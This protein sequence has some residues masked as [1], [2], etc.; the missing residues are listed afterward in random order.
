MRTTASKPPLV[1]DLRHEVRGTGEPLLLVHGTGSS[2]RVWDPLV[3][4]LAA[5]RTVI[6]VDLPGFGASA[7]LTPSGP[8]PPPVSLASSPTSSGNSG[9][10]GAL[11]LTYGASV[12]WLS[13]ATPNDLGQI[14]K[15]SPSSGRVRGAVSTGP[16]SAS[17]ARRP[18]PGRSGR[19]RWRTRRAGSRRCWSS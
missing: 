11:S 16:T 10:A 2:L 13:Q 18:A 3:E 6:A 4:R 19:P 9:T 8:A 1:Q 15:I 17:S 5:R 14:N 12:L 7:P